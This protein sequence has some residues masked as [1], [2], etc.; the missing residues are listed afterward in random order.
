MANPI[1]KILALIVTLQ[2]GTVN[3]QQIY[4]HSDYAF[5]SAQ[6]LYDALELEAPIALGYK[7]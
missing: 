1:L 6:D 3:A 4:K 2:A 7:E 5:M